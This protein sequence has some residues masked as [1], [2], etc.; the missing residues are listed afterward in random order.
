MD[1]KEVNE[2]PSRFQIDDMVFFSINQKVEGTSYFASSL[3]ARVIGIH[4]YPGKVKYDLEIP[5]YDE[6]ATRIY[7]IDS[8]FVEPVNQEVSCGE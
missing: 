1:F 3:K 8:C 4:F 6:S 5:I 7:N 2:L